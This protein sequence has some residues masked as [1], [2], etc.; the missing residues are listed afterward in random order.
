MTS[1]VPIP[2][3]QHK[4]YIIILAQMQLFFQLLHS[5]QK[6]VSITQKLVINEL[7]IGLIVKVRTTRKTGGLL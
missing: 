6:N 3:S 7:A 5:L 4:N 1:N 2:T